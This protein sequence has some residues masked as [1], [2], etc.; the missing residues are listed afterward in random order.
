MIPGVGLVPVTR[1][2]ILI[3]LFVV[4][5]GPVNYYSLRRWGKLN[6]TVL[7]VPTGAIFL[8]AALLLYAL[9]SDGLGVRLRAPEH[10]AHRSNN[11]RSHGAGRGCPYYA[12]LAPAGGLMFSGDTAVVPLEVQPV[13]SIEGGAAPLGRLD[14][15]RSVR[16]EFAIGTTS[17]RRVG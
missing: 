16:A 10:D 6:L 13:A 17:F 1:F 8:T 9:L 7:T 4:V 11:R 12:G 15:N 5:I 2:Q 3:T 14:A